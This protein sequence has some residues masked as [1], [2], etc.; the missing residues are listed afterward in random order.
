MEVLAEWFGV[1][2]AGRPGR[3]PGL[4]LPGW[5]DAMVSGEAVLGQRGEPWGR[6]RFWLLPRPG[7]GRAAAPPRELGASLLRGEA[8]DGG[9]ATL[10]AGVLVERTTPPVTARTVRE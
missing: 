9:L 8:G 4:L 3:W 6:I 2:P 7:F 5:Q 1:E 10:P